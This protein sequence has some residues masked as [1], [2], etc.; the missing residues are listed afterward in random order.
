MVKDNHIE[1]LIVS[2]INIMR[3]LKNNP[4]IIKLM[5]DFETETDYCIVM[6][7]CNEGN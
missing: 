1:S 4:N 5:E 3:A 6:E 2:E 7:F